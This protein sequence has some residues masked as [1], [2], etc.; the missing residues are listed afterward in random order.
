MGPL[1]PIGRPGNPEEI[2]KL[3][4]FL[5]SDDNKFMMGSDITIDGGLHLKPPPL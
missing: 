1:Q 5:I 2:A 4:A 3:L